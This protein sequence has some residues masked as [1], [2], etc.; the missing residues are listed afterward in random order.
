MTKHAHWWWL[1]LPAMA[2][3]LSARGWAEGPYH[4]VDST[5]SWHDKYRRDM[6]NGSFV[7][8]SSTLEFEMD[9]DTR[10]QHILMIEDGK[11]KTVDDCL[12]DNIESC[13]DKAEA[14]NEAHQHRT[15]PKVCNPNAT[16]PTS[17]GENGGVW[18]GRYCICFSITNDKIDCTTTHDCGEG[19]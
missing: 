6:V 14:L 13:L 15:A 1:I 11:N 5:W 2:L 17:C 12:D 4:V 3:F 9:A 8:E 18:Q 16:D 10:T 19:N 7:W